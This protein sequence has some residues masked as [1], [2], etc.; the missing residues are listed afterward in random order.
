MNLLD[1]MPLPTKRARYAKA[2]RKRWE[3]PDYRENQ[4]TAKKRCWERNDY[5]ERQAVSKP[6]RAQAAKAVAAKPER[7]KRISESMKKYLKTLTKEQME[8]RTAGLRAANLRRKPI[9]E[10]K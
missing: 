5:R 7:K 6:K 4:I 10:G 8:K 9:G 3:C 1:M 2:A